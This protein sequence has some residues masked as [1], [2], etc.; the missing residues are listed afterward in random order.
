MLDFAIIILK[1]NYANT[2]LFNFKV[3]NHFTLIKNFYQYLSNT[4][5]IKDSCITILLNAGKIKIL[6]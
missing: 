2:E 5:I 6:K 4:H 3:T 1:F